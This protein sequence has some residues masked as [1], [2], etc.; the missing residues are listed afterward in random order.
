MER[1]HGEAAEPLL[2]W[3]M[4]ETRRPWSVRTREGRGA[5]RGRLRRIPVAVTLAVLASGTSAVAAEAAPTGPVAPAP[6]AAEPAKAKP[7]SWGRAPIAGEK[8]TVKGKVP[9]SGR[10]R[11]VKVQLKSK[12]RWRT[13]ASV[14][15][16][17]NGKFRATFRARKAGALRVTS[18]ASGRKRAHTTKA[19]KLTLAKQSGTLSTPTVVLRTQQATMKATFRP[20]RPGRAVVLSGRTGGGGWTQVARGVQDGR[21]RVTFTVLAST[22]GSFEYRATAAKAKGAKARSSAVRRMRID[23]FDVELH[24]DV[25]VL[26]E[27]EQRSVQGVDLASGTVTF[28][29]ATAP[30]LTQ[31][32]VISIAPTAGAPSGALRRVT[33]VTTASGTVRAVTTDATL[34]DVVERMPETQGEVVMCSIA[35][36]VSVTP[37]TTLGT[38]EPDNP[39]CAAAPLSGSQPGRVATATGAVVVTA[40]KIA[41]GLANKG[42]LTSSGGVSA[43]YSIEGKVSAGPVFELGIGTTFYGK[44]TSYRAGGGMEWASSTTT[45]VKAAATFTEKVETKVD[46]A[47]VSRTFKGMIGP[48]PVW[49]DLSG[50]LVASVGLEGSAAVT[51][52]NQRT[53]RDMAGIRNKGS[54]KL[55][56]TGYH[57]AA[58]STDRVTEVSG[59][60]TVSGGVGAEMQLDAYS[61]AGPFLGMGVRGDFTASWGATTGTSCVYARGPYAEI[62]LRTSDLVNKLTGGSVQGEVS[63]E[64]FAKVE[65]PNVCPTGTDLD[66]D[67]VPVIATTALPKATFESPYAAQLQAVKAPG[68]VWSKVSGSFPSGITMDLGGRLSGTPRRVGTSSFTVK[69]TGANG[70]SATRALTLVVADTQPSACPTTDLVAKDCAALME[71][72]R[73]NPGLGWNGPDACAWAGVTCSGGRVHWLRLAGQG[74]TTL[75]G[76]VGN[77]TDLDQLV[78]EQTAVA[79]LPPEIGNLSSLRSLF[80]WTSRL[81]TVPPEIGKLSTL[82]ELALEGSEIAALPPQIGDLTELRILGLVG[83]KITALPRE[84]GGLSQLETLDVAF[85]ELTTLPQEVWG[86]TSLK[87]LSYQD[88]QVS[89]AVPPQVG[90]LTQLETLSIMNNQIPSIPAEIGNLPRLWVFYASDNPLRTLPATVGNLKAVTTMTFGRAGLSGDISAWARPLR[91]NNPDVRLGLGGNDCLDVGGDAALASW[92]DAQAEGWRDGC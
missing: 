82:R 91:A 83:N 69:V 22:V 81:T 57:D 8:V 36:E 63:W 62:G 44:V 1:P 14:R 45:T 86:I 6:A 80:V 75:P 9:K 10:A 7:F 76:A 46:L 15:S 54:G 11:R 5:H 39:G 30:R 13:V 25:L 64:F 51:L 49:G 37:G 78:L 18:P 26:T 88:N 92:L 55:S 20:A 50:T 42:S 79:S 66:P 23:E 12:G 89:T 21:G 48:V 38:V 85:N 70:K 68:A 58:T 35:T 31:G 52:V 84:V 67:V 61:V 65:T 90:N 27:A 59:A 77:L 40:P 41:L 43:A 71:I 3:P 4:G 24:D 87:H 72:R 19:R 60:V 56:P 73:L 17:K 33:S 34:L 74:M 2:C 16:K 53:G 47:E 28:A 32:N 29:A